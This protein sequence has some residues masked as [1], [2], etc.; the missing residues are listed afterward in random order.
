MGVSPKVLVMATRKRILL[1]LVFFLMLVVFLETTAGQ[2]WPVELA[3]SPSIKLAARELKWQR[4]GQEMP[5]D[6]WD[7]KLDKS[8]KLRFDGK[9]TQKSAPGESQIESNPGVRPDS[10]TVREQKL[11]AKAERIQEDERLTREKRARVIRKKWG[12][13]EESSPTVHVEYSSD[14]NSFGKI[15]YRKGHLRIGAIA[16]ASLL[17]A[18]L[19][20]EKMLSERLAFMMLRQSQP[21]ITDLDGQVR[22]LGKTRPVARSKIMEFA[23]RAAQSAPPAQAFI[24]PDGVKRLRKELRVELMPDN[25]QTRAQQHLPLVEAV[26]RTYNLPPELIMAIIHTEST[27]NPRAESHAGAIGLMQLIPSTGAM[28]ASKVVYG[29][30]RLIGREELYRPD[31]NVEL[32]AA[33][34]HVLMRKHFKGY[35]NDPEKL[36][37]LAI[38]SY[39]CG[40]RRV[41]MAIGYDDI[42][43]LSTTELYGLLV[44]VVPAET[45]GYLHRVIQRMRKY[46]PEHGKASWPTY[47]LTDFARPD[48]VSSQLF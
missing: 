42:R 27:F 36:C 1:C 28:D 48:S 24:A 16:P 25:L 21:G 13:Y 47:V 10:E 9:G 39:N 23:R 37:F 22:M 3:D 4:V 7:E 35:T 6:L 14:N 38:A 32:G 17:N 40:P 30:P 18:P 11:R 45:Q 43:E 46:R 41:K 33:Y 26:A 5:K 12:S 19:R 15:D 8:N 29:E 31:K 20:T 44:S 34:L 2:L